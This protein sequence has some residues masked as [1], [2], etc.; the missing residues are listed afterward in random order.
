MLWFV[1]VAMCNTLSVIMTWNIWESLY[2]PYRSP[3]WRYLRFIA[4]ILRTSTTSSRETTSSILI[5]YVFSTIFKLSLNCLSL[6]VSLFLGWVK[7]HGKF[8]TLC[9]MWHSNS[10]FI[11]KSLYG[12]I[13]TWN[14]N[15]LSSR[16]NNNCLQFEFIWY[17]WNSKVDD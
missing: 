11:A 3:E 9:I 17:M 14:N 1:I 16:N 12:V 8:K 10:D 15:K 4:R 13:S 5:N 7:C 2:F 6:S